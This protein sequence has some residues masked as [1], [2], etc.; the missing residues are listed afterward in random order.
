MISV[1]VFVV[2]F[3]ILMDATKIEFSLLVDQLVEEIIVNLGLFYIYT[4][5]KQLTK[6]EERKTET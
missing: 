5:W 3:V 2:V 6:N 4:Q 1:V